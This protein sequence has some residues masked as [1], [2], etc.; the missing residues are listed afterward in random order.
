MGGRVGTW[1]NKLNTLAD[2][3][4]P[5]S[6]KII[7]QINHGY[8]KIKQAYGN[9]LGLNRSNIFLENSLSSRC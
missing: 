8:T 4:F 1:M 7:R 2:I 6:I 3:Q 5:M 9:S